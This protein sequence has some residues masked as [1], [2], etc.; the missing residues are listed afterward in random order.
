[1]L[2]GP[3]FE[4]SMYLASRAGAAWASTS[5]PHRSGS[6]RAVEHRANNA[7]PDHVAAMA[8]AAW[9]PTVDSCWSVGGLAGV[10]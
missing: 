7:D 4:K 5:S 3:S 2:P 10:P 9:A 6:L 1:M 8:P